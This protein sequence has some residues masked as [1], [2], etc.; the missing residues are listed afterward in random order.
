MS[1][2]HSSFQKVFYCPTCSSTF[3]SKANLSRHRNNPLCPCYG[4]QAEELPT[5]VG[6]PMNLEAD[7]SME[8][9]ES[10]HFPSPA[11]QEEPVTQ[12]HETPPFH[13]VYHPHEP[14]TRLGGLSF[15]DKFH[16]D[17][18]SEYRVKHPY[19]P[20]ANRAEWDAA[21]YC[22]NKTA[23]DIKHFIKLQIVGAFLF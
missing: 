13:I 23:E 15:M 21:C 6:S 10:F 4:R 16:Q 1:A 14:T 18:Y 9:M 19:Y 20:F 8:I 5:S 2:L 12:E 7:V 3:N 11:P 22:S 17:K